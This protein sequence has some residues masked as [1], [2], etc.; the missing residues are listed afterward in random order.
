[1]AYAWSATK[2]ADLR[3]VEP[4]F[5]PDM[6]RVLSGSWLLSIDKARRVLGYQP[7]YPDTLA[8]IRAAYA[9][10]FAGKASHCARRTVDRSAR[11]DSAPAIS[12]D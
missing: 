6:I 10:V 11:S 3:H 5:V 9:E 7:E 12:G 4:A 2:L 1:M 8:G